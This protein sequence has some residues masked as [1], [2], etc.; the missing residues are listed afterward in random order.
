MPRSGMA[1][2]AARSQFRRIFA[3]R[4]KRLRE[5]RGL[6]QSDVALRLRIGLEAYKKAEQRG[7]LAV[8]LLLPLADILDVEVNYLLTGRDSPKPRPKKIAIRHPVT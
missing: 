8:D 3:N 5:Q 7:S 1:K 4:I 2:S 6:S